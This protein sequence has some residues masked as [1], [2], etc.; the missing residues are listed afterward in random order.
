[1]IPEGKTCSKC[2]EWKPLTDYHRNCAQKDGRLTFCRDCHNAGQ[3]IDRRKKNPNLLVRHQFVNPFSGFLDFGPLP[4]RSTAACDR[5]IARRK[6]VIAAEN[7]TLH[8]MEVA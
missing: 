2:K 5:E 7:H 1:M 4:P 3:R 6:F 8:V